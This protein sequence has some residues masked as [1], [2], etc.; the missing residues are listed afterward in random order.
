MTLAV[1]VTTSRSVFAV[2][3]SGVL[4]VIDIPFVS[5]PVPIFSLQITVPPAPSRTA[6]SV[7]APSASALN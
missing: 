1:R 5:P 3:L 6:I 7:A 2:P 4:N